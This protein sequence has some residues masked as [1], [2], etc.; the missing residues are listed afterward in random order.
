MA[1]LLAGACE[2]GQDASTST[3]GTNTAGAGGAGASGGSG[4]GGGITPPCNPICSD[5]LHAVVDCEG[6]I[7]TACNDDEGCDL[8]TAT[9]INACQ[10]SENAKRSVGCEYYAVQMDQLNAQACFAAFVANTWNTPAH[11]SVERDGQ[12]L[13]IETFAYLP[14]GFGPSLTYTP[15]DP[16]TGLMPGEV[17]ILF[18]AGD[19]GTP[20]PGSP[21]CPVMSAT[22]A[23]TQ[24]VGTGRGHGFRVQSDVPVVSYQINPYGGGSAAIT[25]ASLLLPTSAW[26][27]DYLAMHAYHSGPHPTSFNVV[28]REDDTT[29]TLLPSANIDGGGG[30]PPGSANDDYTVTLAAGEYIQLTQE[31]ELDGSIVTSDKPVGFLAGARCSFV[32]SGVQACDHL[33]QM[34]PP[35]RALGHHYAGVSH[36]TR[37]GE[38][39]LWRLLGVVD[40]TTLSWSNDVGGPRTID[41]GE[42][43]EVTTSF[44]FV[45]E[46]QD[47]DHPFVLM[48]HMTGGATN[49]MNGV[50]DADAVLAVPPEQYLSSYV[51][52]TD[53]TYPATHVVVV[54]T[55]KDGMFHDVELDCAGVIGGWKKLGDFE[56]TY[57]DLMT[58]DF[59]PAGNCSTGLRTMRS[60]ARFGVWVWG[61]GSPQ[62]TDF[63]AYV[64]YGYPAGMNVQLIN[65]VELE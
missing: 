22:P 34:I 60:D 59:E 24:V 54:R 47:A 65:A 35:V 7:L 18:L 58:G 43:V 14:I 42:L 26:G 50:G 25:G 21:V 57:V 28:A 8:E 61:W 13:A 5:D 51:F 38:P 37:S 46:S 23:G 11:I 16:V 40:G 48:A 41:R 49:G 1:L 64:S 12:P 30:L 19:Q 10:A 52:F 45:V 15:Y 3:S 9:C 44:P 32:P 55:Q 33:E 6:T 20:G 63:T 27:Q 2:A 36:R 56:Y 29:V 53:P 17:A 39:S 31:S 4:M 62:T